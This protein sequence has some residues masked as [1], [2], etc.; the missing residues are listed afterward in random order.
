VTRV[1][2]TLIEHIMRDGKVIS[3]SFE[4]SSLEQLHDEL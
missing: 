3:S 2:F 1:D 4:E